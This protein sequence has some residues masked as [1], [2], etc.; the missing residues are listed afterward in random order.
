MIDNNGS[1]DRLLS[2]RSSAGGQVTLLG[3]TSQGASTMKVVRAISIPADSTVRFDPDGFHML[4]TGSGPMRSGTEITLK[5][6]FAKAGT[7]SVP[8]LVENPES[9]GAS[10]LGD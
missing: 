7:I 6:V 3:P 2:A 5:L 9:G 8:T 10:Y 4:I 1:P